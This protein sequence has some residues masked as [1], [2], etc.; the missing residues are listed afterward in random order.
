LSEKQGYF[1]DI[2]AAKKQLQSIDMKTLSRIYGRGRG[3]VFT[4]NDFSD[5]GSQDAVHQALSRHARTGT[6][7]KLARGLYDFPRQH[8]KLG[9]IPPSDENIAKA[10]NGRH[11]TRIQLSGAHAANMLGLSTQV[12][13]R[14]VFLTD[15]DSRKVQLGPR[16]I[17]LKKTTPRQMATAGRVSGLVI[18]ALRWLGA[19]NVDDK[20]IATLRRRLGPD[21]KK[22]LLA[23]IRYAPDWVAQIMRQVAAP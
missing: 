7:R 18:Q 2:M 1:P 19:T 8:P 21:E 13:M 4:P 10:L 14:T 20:I 12:P 6:I 23:D 22:Q 15:G 5:L 11:S 17:V 9:L 16:Q 3:C